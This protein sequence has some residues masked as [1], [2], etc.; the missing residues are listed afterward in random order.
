MKRLVVVAVAAMCCAA[1]AEGPEGAAPR[2]GGH[3]P[4]AGPRDFGM[5]FDPIV[6]IVSNP[7]IVD[8]LGLSEEQQDKL[9]AVGKSGG[10]VRANQKKVR[11]ATMRQDELMKADKVDEAEVMKAIDE[12]F[13][14]RKEMAKEQARRVVAIKSILTPEQIAKAREEMKSFAG[15]RGKGRGPRGGE[16][17]KGPRKG[18]EK[19]APKPEAE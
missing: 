4:W 19:P 17:G 5:G 3:R 11:E 8:K 16:R 2:E 12:V 6:R 9:K 1:F 15:S 10:N 7:A 18:V 13:E 14:L